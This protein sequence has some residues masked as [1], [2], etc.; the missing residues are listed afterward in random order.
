MFNLTKD[1]LKI[2][3]KLN[4]PIKI[5]DFLDT[6][7]INFEKKGDTN[8]SPRQVLKHNKAHCFEGALF[9]ATALWIHGQRPLVLELKV[10]RDINHMIA[11]YKVDGHWGAISKTNHLALRFR[12]PIYKTIRELVMSYMHECW[13]DTTGKKVLVGYAGPFDMKQ[14]GI[15]WI[16]TGEDLYPIAEKFY[17]TKTIRLIDKKQERYLRPADAFERTLGSITEWENEY[18]KR[19]T[20]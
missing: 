13:K 8:M 20:I 19:N 3:K 11:L 10:P 16:T 5:Q 7:S 9:A 4:T 17:D 15:D 2:F 1:E 14:F 12:D 18:I 6:L